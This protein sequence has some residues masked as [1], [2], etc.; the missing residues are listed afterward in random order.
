[1]NINRDIPTE[2]GVILF[3]YVLPFLLALTLATNLLIVVVLSQAHMRTSTNLVLLAMAISD[4]LTIL[5]PAP[6]YFYLY[7]LGHHQN[8]IYPPRNCYLFHCMHEVLPALFHTYSIWLTLLLAG[9]RLVNVNNICFSALIFSILFY[10]ILLFG[11]WAITNSSIATR[12]IYVCHFS[13][14][15]TWCTVPRV[16]RAIVFILIMAIVHQASRFCDRIFL[17]VRFIRNDKVIEGCEFLTAAWVS[18]THSMLITI[19]FNVP[20]L[21]SN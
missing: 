14:A 6:W 19:H 13:L 5:S 12:Y 9:Q 1:M 7:T 4:L 21:T 15:R 17:T 20:A 10:S 11:V 8:A 16:V 2:L 18:R 3:G